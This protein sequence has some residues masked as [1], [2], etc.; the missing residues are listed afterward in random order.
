MAEEDNPLVSAAKTLGKL[1][2]NVAKAVGVTADQPEQSPA[3]GLW[4][5]RYVGSGAFIVKKPKRS[6]HKMHE[7]RVRSRVRRARK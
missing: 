1:A 3:E 5:A 6:K 2:G 4:E 7:T